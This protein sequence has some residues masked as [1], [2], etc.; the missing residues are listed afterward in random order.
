MIE[1]CRMVWT[2]DLY[3]MTQD[4]VVSSVLGH[5]YYITTPRETRALH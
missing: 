2:F 1:L 3:N 5:E 4:C